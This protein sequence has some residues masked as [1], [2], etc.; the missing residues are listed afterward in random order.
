MKRRRALRAQPDQGIIRPTAHRG[1][2][3][4]GRSD[5]HGASSSSPPSDAGA[6]PLKTPPTP[7]AMRFPPLPG[8]HSSSPP[9]KPL[10]SHAMACPPL[11]E[12]LLWSRN[13]WPQGTSSNHT[14]AWSRYGCFL[15]DSGFLPPPPRTYHAMVCPPLLEFVLGTWPSDARAMPEKTHL[16][17]ATE[18]VLLALGFTS[19]P[20]PTL[21][22]GN[23]A[24][25]R[26]APRSGAT[27]DPGSPPS[28]PHPRP[29]SLASP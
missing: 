25:A 20:S 6:L 2:L 27:A 24:H 22:V 14:T 3:A 7:Y 16:T 4:P 18:L 1:R 19:A 13:H 17:S 11:R 21:A 26:S 8:P 23:S 12:I 10:T 28:W 29:K 5:G 9:T 15:P